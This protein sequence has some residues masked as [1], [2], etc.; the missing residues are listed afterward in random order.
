MMP[1]A[2]RKSRRNDDNHQD[3]GAMTMMCNDYTMMLIVNDSVQP[4]TW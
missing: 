1:I 3:D 4:P 2:P